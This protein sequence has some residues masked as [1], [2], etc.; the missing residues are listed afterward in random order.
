MEKVG[1]I[2]LGY[3]GLPLAAEFG[4]VLQV[5]GFDI[6]RDRI[7]ELKKGFD[8]T[9]EVD[10]DELNKSKYLTFSCET[11]ELKSVNY[12]NKKIIWPFSYWNQGNFNFQNVNPMFL[13]F[14]DIVLIAA[15]AS[16]E[17]GNSAD[18]LKYLEQ[19]R[20]RAR[21]S[22]TFAASVAAGENGGAGILPQIL[23]IDKTAL[24]LAI[25]HERRVELAM[26]FNRWFDLVRYNNV[27]AANGSD[28]TGYTESLLKNTYGRT[29]FNYAKFSRFPIPA[30]H[31]TSSNGVLVQNDGWK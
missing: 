26:E 12:T 18:A 25:W 19:I 17:L 14:A 13:R 16:N 7:N 31:I 23:T 21:G 9:R 15:E 3:V 4:K 5:V 29:N 8:R 20:Y 28:G 22:K 1:I 10:A 2:G 6:N 30:T 11:D 24:R 27:A